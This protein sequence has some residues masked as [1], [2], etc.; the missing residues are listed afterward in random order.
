MSDLSK[1]PP[2]LLVDEA[3]LLN[4]AQAVGVPVLRDLLAA[5]LRDCAAAAHKIETVHRSNEAALARE[6][7]KLG[8]LFMQFGCPA[9]GH[10]FKAA[11]Q[12]SPEE[13]PPYVAAALKLVEPTLAELR[14]LLSRGSSSS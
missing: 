3:Y 9:A 4:L 11:A 2:P 1:T 14:A 7:H 5:T 6:A 12:A 13:R 10:A 8:G